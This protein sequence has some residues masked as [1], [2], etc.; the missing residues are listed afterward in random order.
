MDFSFTPEQEA[1]RAAVRTLMQRHAPPESL[2]AW[3]R[4]Q[5]F[6]E[7]LYATWAEAGL[8]R[9]PFPEETW[10]L[11]G[12]VLD[13]V[14]VAEEVA[15]GSADLFMAFA[16]SVFCGLNILRKGSAEQ[17]GRWLPR[18]MAGE[19]RM[20]IAISEPEA[21]SDLSGL[22][23]RAVRD[24]DGWV[25][26]GG[27]IW[28]TGAGLPGSVINAYVRT[29]EDA[30]V[31]KSLSL[32]L[33]PNDAP[34]V[35]LRKLDMLGRRMTGTYE[36]AFDSV[37]VPG[38][39]LIGGENRGWECLL[40]GLQAE[41]IVSAAGNIGA[42]SAAL[43]LA[44]DHARQRR[45]F[46]R[47]IGEFQAIAHLLADRAA[48]LEAVRTLVWRAAW[49]VDQGRDALREIS[50]AK[51]LSSELYARI[52]AEG[53]QVMGAQGFSMDGDMQ[54][55]F[56]DSRSATIAAGTSQMQRNII[57]GLMGLRPR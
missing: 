26:E 27:K 11:G 54:R 23:T 36:V 2:R 43:D 14:L 38:E 46:G 30:D 13:L 7:P 22:R 57:A 9:L 19:V 1:M 12:G 32:F 15:R 17:R 41:R 55:H 29:G 34:G 8:F 31:R 25:I 48:E 50:M 35:R 3:D 45:Q 33:V 20:S 53:M 49:L 37:R 44:L 40:A 56:R 21:G 5:Q 51:L 16:G 39:H 24:G 52:A 18:V 28:T 6:P 47:P 10:G 42:A 4:A